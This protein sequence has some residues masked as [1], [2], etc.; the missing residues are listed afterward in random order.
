M[1]KYLVTLE[2]AIEV[3]AES[4]FHAKEEALKKINIRDGIRAI[5]VET[6]IEEGCQFMGFAEDCEN[7]GFCEKEE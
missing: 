1:D 4:F 3:E 7:C 2:V 5:V 6:E